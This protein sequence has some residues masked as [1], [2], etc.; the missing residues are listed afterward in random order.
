MNYWEAF[1]S[2]Y[3]S[4]ASNRLRTF[5]TTLGALIGVMA[6]ITLVSVTLGE[7]KTLPAVLHRA[8]P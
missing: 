2:A 6:V 5:L 3:S 7:V 1:K 4:L 8:N